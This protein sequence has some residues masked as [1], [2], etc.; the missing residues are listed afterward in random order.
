M[1]LDRILEAHRASARLDDRRLDLLIADAD[2]MPAPRGFTAALRRDAQEHLAV[3]AEVK[4]RSPSKGDLAVDL[5]PAATAVAYDAGGASCLSVLTDAAHF[6]GSPSDLRLARAAV[7]LPVLRKDFT[8]DPRDICDARLM[9]ADAVLLIVAAL[10]DEELMELHALAVELRLDVLVEVHD[11]A[12]LERALAA[13]A[14]LVGVNQR[15]LQTFEVDHDRAVR[16]GQAMPEGVVRVAESGVR[17]PDDA[18]ALA[19]AG[20]HAVLVGESV[21]TAGDPAASVASLRAARR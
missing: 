10:D 4:R 3:I 8:V 6:G 15:D 20:F 17:G 19:D 12:E 21:V 16:V 7:T 1:Y 18:R 14:T 2:A 13:G 9:G 5:D 11:E